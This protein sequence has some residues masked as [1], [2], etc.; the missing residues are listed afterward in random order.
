[1]YNDRRDNLDLFT[2]VRF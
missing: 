2:H 1:M